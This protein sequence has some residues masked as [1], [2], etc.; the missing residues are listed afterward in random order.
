MPSRL[1]TKLRKGKAGTLSHKKQARKAVKR[2]R[3][4]AA[5]QDQGLVVTEDQFMDHEVLP[6]PSQDVSTHLNFR[7]KT[8]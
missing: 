4:H 3:A 2:A 8:T 1:I 6:D 5:K 7:R